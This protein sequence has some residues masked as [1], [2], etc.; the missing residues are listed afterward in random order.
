MGR[1]RKG[2]Y[3]M[4]SRLVSAVLASLVPRMCE[5]S[6]PPDVGFLADPTDD[7]PSLAVASPT[8]KREKKTLKALVNKRFFADTMFSL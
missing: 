2:T 4:R 8:T 6:Q 1:V 5:S 3:D 7:F